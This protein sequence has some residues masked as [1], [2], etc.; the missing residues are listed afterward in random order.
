MGTPDLLPVSRA[1]QDGPCHLG[2]HIDH[3]WA[4]KPSPEGPVAI[5]KGHGVPEQ[6]QVFYPGSAETPV[7]HGGPRVREEVLPQIQLTVGLVGTRGPRQSPHWL[8][9]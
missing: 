6:S 9:L 3:E 5:F 8:Q 1:G 2:T 4:P 7:S